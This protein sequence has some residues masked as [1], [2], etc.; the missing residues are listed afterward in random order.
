VENG[1]YKANIGYEIKDQNKLKMIR[2]SKKT[3]YIH[4]EVCEIVS[5][6]LQYKK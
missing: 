5:R 1:M 2:L 6:T 4:K 3:I